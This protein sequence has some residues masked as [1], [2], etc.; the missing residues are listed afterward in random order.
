MSDASRLMSGA[1]A[2]RFP[3]SALIPLFATSDLFLVYTSGLVLRLMTE[4][5]NRTR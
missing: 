3:L 5:W 1:E 2:E 4:R